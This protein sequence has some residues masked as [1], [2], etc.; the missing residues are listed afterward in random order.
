MIC[1]RNHQTQNSF[2]RHH[3]EASIL[4]TDLA[5]VHFSE[6]RLLFHFVSASSNNSSHGPN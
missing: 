5:S 6:H 4:I 1:E 2:G 3:V